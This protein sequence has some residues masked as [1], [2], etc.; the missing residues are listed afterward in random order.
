[1]RFSLRALFVLVTL[2]CLYLGWQSRIVGERVA[3]VKWL[4]TSYGYENASDGAIVVVC[5]EN[6]S[7]LTWVRRRFGDASYHWSCL[8]PPTERE[9]ARMMSAFPQA[10]LYTQEHRK[11]RPIQPGEE[12]SLLQSKQP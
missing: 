5:Q 4:Q 7:Q 9:R 10:K 12:I 11:L 2:C 8:L 3:V 1:M 6:D